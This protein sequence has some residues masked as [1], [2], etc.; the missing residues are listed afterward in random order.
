MDETEHPK[1]AIKLDH[2]GLAVQDLE[3]IRELFSKMLG[4][5][6]SEVE[7]VDSQKVRVTFADAGGTG[8]EL[9]Q[10]TDDRSPH[11]PILKHP[12][13]GFVEKHGNGL[14]HISFQVPNLEEVAAQLEEQGIE[15]LTRGIMKGSKGGNV[16]F[17]NPRHTTGL[18]IELNEH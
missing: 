15:L 2:V 6:F 17:I 5:V 14:H 10:A 1:Q 8:I 3:Q 9:I 18:L 7:E 12:I 4:L 11:F 13:S 16:A